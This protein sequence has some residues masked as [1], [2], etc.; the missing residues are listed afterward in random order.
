MMKLN[1]RSCII[2]KQESTNLDSEKVIANFAFIKGV[3]SHIDELEL[4]ITNSDLKPHYK[5]AINKILT[6][7]QNYNFNGD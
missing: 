4:A 6:A 5:A 1:L 2:D 3:I 7:V